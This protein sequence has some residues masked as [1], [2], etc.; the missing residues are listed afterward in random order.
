MSADISAEKVLF[1]KVG[2]SLFHNLVLEPANDVVNAFARANRTDFVNASTSYAV[3]EDAGWD[4]I[5]PPE[6]TQLV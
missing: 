6:K 4:A 3:K 5:Y 1:A 2:H